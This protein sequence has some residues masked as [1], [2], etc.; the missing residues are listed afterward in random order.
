MIHERPKDN[1]PRMVFS[2]ADRDNL[3]ESLYVPEMTIAEVAK[4]LPGSRV[5]TWLEEPET[6]AGDIFVFRWGRV[7]NV[8][9]HTVEFPDVYIEFTAHPQRHTSAKYWYAPFVLHGTE[10]TEYMAFK[11]GTTT[12]PE[13]SLDKDAPLVKVEKTPEQQ[14]MEA[15]V[16]Y[17]RS[18]RPG[19]RERMRKA[20]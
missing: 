7:R 8:D 11:A 18:R 4:N 6:R 2:E 12:N 16:R 19:K 17:L 15:K 9:G 1:L 5:F 13:E 3:D 20:A 10:K 14:E